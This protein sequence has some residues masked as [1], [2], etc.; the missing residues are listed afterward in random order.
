MYV[1]TLKNSSVNISQLLDGRMPATEL[2]HHVVRAL[3]Q[4]LDSFAQVGLV[5]PSRAWEDHASLQWSSTMFLYVWSSWLQLLFFHA[6][7]TIKWKKHG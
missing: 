5:P 2:G 7:Y 6:P 1:G 4:P 3:V